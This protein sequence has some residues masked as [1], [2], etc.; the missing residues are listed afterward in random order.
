MQIGAFAVSHKINLQR[1]HVY[2]GFFNSNKTVNIEL[3]YCYTTTAHCRIV[4]RAE[5]V[6]TVVFLLLSGELARL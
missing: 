3:S 4:L 2:F 6:R 5:V 1:K